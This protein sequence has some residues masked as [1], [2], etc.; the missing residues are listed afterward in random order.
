MWRS[1]AVSELVYYQKK[2][3][4]ADCVPSEMQMVELRGKH[5]YYLSSKCFLMK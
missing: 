1:E 5:D 4:M 2:E 3:H